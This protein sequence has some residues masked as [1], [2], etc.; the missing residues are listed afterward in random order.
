MFPSPTIDT[1]SE[2]EDENRRPKRQWREK[3]RRNSI[4]AIFS[5]PEKMK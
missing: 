4:Y 3:D 5:Y 1:R 2:S